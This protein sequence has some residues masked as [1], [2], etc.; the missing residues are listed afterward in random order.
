MRVA[1]ADD[2]AITREALKTLL[3]ATEE[4][5]VTW[6]VA[7]GA[8]A[9]AKCQETCPGAECPEVLLMDLRMQRM[10]G[11]TAVRKICS[12]GD[13]PKIVIVSSLSSGEKIKEAFRA[14]A[15]GYFA[16]DDDP[17]M[18]V[19]ALRRVLEGECVFSPTCS[20]QVMEE[21]KQAAPNS[22][23]RLAEENAG[24]QLLTNREQ[25]ILGMI[26]E[27]L[28]NEAIAKRAGIS[29]ETVKTHVKAIIAKCGVQDRAGAVAYGFR[30]GLID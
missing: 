30:H 25:E 19:S 8:D 7:D 11:I 22:S 13:A 18:I 2:D 15:A 26:A 20:L 4:V 24:R 5:S 29:L 3:E 12:L 6:T 23:V 27:S 1:I 17:R 9:V 28:S 16:K 14:G 10:D 21:L